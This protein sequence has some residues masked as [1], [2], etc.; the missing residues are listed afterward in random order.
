MSGTSPNDGFD[1]L[2]EATSGLV[3]TK[4][5]AGGA[6]MQPG[7][8]GGRANQQRRDRA[9]QV[10]PASSKIRRVSCTV[11]L[12]AL[13]LNTRIS[14]Q[15]FVRAPPVTRV[16]AKVIRFK[17]IAD[18]GE[19]PLTYDLAI[20]TPSSNRK[21]ALGHGALTSDDLR[22]GTLLEEDTIVEMSDVRCQMSEQ[23]AEGRG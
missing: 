3:K 15:P 2:I 23:R 5:D 17:N 21:A 8:D 13:P 1:I 6:I 14:S 16:S 10:T 22:H 11:W 19:M 9:G 7:D 18:T 12:V 20:A 4:R